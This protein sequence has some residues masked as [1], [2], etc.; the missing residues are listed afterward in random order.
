MKKHLLFLDALG[1]CVLTASILF[2][3]LASIL[4]QEAFFIYGLLTAIPLAFW[5]L[6]SALIKGVA[7]SSQPHLTYMAA[8]VGYCL[9]LP[10]AFQAF[11]LAG[12]SYETALPLLACLPP[13]TGACWYSY[14]SVQD[15]KERGAVHLASAFV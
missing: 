6:S 2:S 11:P 1:Q 3:V 4:M 5:Q 14:R 12:P 10:A 7:W 8:A 15:Y 9:L 13:L